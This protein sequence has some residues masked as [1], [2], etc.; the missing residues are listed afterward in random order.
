MMLRPILAGA[1]FFAALALPTI[2]AAANGYATGTVNMRA[3]PSTQYPV[4]T[5]IPAGAPVTIYGC[6]GGWSWCD[7]AWAGA[8]GW[9]YA[10][11]L[12]GVHGAQRVY[13]P[14]YAP[15]IGIPVISFSFSTYWDT[16]YRYRP[17]YRDRD[18]W[19]AYWRGHRY[20]R[21]RDD[22]RDRVGDRPRDDDRREVRQDRREFQQERQQDRRREQVRERLQDQ[23][24]DARQERRQEQRQE[25]R[26]ER[27]QEQRQ[28]ARQ[29]RRQDRRG[30]DDCRRRGGEV[31]CQ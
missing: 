19:Y 26:Q 30:G 17:W 5:T 15:Q 28:E 31:V 8:R 3:G 16:H 24:Q 22:W 11:Y 6:E 7:T 23:R 18:R 4:I 25:V 13:L 12:E 14:T 20:D 2:A 10:R 29:E 27:R 21:D 1:A 9:V